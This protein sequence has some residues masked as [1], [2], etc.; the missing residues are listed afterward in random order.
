MSNMWTQ[1][2]VPLVEAVATTT[3]AGDRVQRCARLASRP[4]FTAWTG[5]GPR[6][7]RKRFKQ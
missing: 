1:T 2:L 6:E 4:A 3:L 5:S 7:Y